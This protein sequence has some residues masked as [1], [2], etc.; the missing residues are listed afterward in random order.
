MVQTTRFSRQ[1]LFEAG[2]FGQMTEGLPLHPHSAGVATKLSV[3]VP[4][5]KSCFADWTGFNV[6]R[7]SLE[8]SH[9]IKF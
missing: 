6:H 7:L 4:R 1:D 9:K 2:R 8:L 5:F 3:R